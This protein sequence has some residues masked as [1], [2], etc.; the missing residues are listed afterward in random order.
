M[1]LSN[2]MGY[3]EGVM[4]KDIFLILEDMNDLVRT[5]AA[6]LKISSV[7][8]FAVG[9]ALA[10]VVG[11]FGYKLIKLMM[12]VC[13]GSVGYLVGVE[14]FFAFYKHYEKLPE[15]CSYIAGGLIAIVFICLAYRHFSY[16]LY[17]VSAICGYVIT[18]FYIDNVWVAI[19]GAIVL[20]MLSIIILRVFF[21]LATSLLAGAFAGNCLVQIL[22][23]N[24]AIFQGEI[25][26]W[27]PA[28]IM[29]A[30]ALFFT[31]IQLATNRRRAMR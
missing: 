24:L 19:G 15:W 16:A 25:G 13:M 28:A 21:V 1:G 20:A 31:I 30:F 3:L 29:L 7:I 14:L 10:C 5:W 8:F 23:A 12:A 4:S 26:E 9:I 11:L 2:L 6:D 27:V 18:S 17:T 22:P